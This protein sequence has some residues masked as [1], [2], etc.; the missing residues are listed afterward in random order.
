MKLLALLFLLLFSASV[1]AQSTIDFEAT[2]DTAG[3]VQFSNVAN[4]PNNFVVTTNPSVTPGM[5]ATAN[6]A[7]LNILAG[8]DPWAG[9]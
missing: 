8:A 7:E 3:W 4:D 2:T 9:V 5:N 6:A 1:F